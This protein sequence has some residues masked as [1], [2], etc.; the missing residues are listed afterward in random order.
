MIR[1]VL[2]ALMSTSSIGSIWTATLSGMVVTSRQ[3]WHSHLHRR[4]G[5]ARRR[6]SAAAV[7]GVFDDL[8]VARAVHGHDI[9]TA[10]SERRAPGF[11]QPDLGRREDPR[12]LAAR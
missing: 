9:E 2:S 7:E 10:G 3:E 5:F 6:R 8:A 1:K 12:L 11:G 4:A